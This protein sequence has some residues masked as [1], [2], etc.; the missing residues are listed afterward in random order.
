MSIFGSSW[1]YLLIYQVIYFEDLPNV[2]VESNLPP[3]ISSRIIHLDDSTR[4]EARSPTR[5]RQFDNVV[6]SD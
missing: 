1:S 4:V 5:R 3:I 2:L 6:F